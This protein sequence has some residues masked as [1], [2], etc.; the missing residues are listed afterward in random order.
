M[1]VIDTRE[2]KYAHIEEYFKKNNIC[3]CKRKLS[4]G[5]YYNTENKTVL[6]DRKAN[7]QEICQNLSY[8]KENRTRF[9]KECKRAFEHNVK[10][11][12]LIEGTSIQSVSELS[13]W[14]S[15]YSKHTGK[16]LASEMF[17]LSRAYNVE[18]QFC[19]KNE[20]AK[21]ILELLEYD[22]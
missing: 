21:K 20:T 13:K 12:V 1:I 14:K 22:K 10:F 7:L 17:N 19:K 4:T 18:W 11:I 9:W 8:G 6:I 5:D 16:W 15:K 2:K 3:Y